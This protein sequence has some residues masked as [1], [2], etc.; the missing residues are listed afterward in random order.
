MSEKRALEDYE[1]GLGLGAGVASPNDDVPD[2]RKTTT[3]RIGALAFRA[4]FALVVLAACA[5]IAWQLSSALLLV[6]GLVLAASVFLSTH[7]I[8]EWE[9]GVVLRFGKLNRVRG[10]GIFFTIPLVE[11]V[12]AVV[13]LR[14]RSTV[15][16]AERVLTSDL[17]PVNVD[18]VLFWLVWDAGKACTEIKN[19]E[20]SVFWISQTTLRDAIGG[21]SI[22]QMSTR[23]VQLDKEVKSVLEAKMRDWGITTVSVEIRDIVIPME[24]Q[25]VLSV[26]AQA[27]REYNARVILA[28]VEKEISEMFVDAARVYKQEDAALQLRA[29]SFVSNSVKD[30]GGLVVIPSG[31]SDAFDGL[32]RIAKGQGI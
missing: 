19:F 15:F 3:S 20:E 14:L 4:T 5:A 7:I 9:H 26:E 28:E 22:A 25:N 27:E 1:A 32:E 18:A 29:M 12:T 23:R 6:V 8:L 21:M 30:K 17:V 11:Y 13:D 2:F 24:L 16:K 31:L 10:S